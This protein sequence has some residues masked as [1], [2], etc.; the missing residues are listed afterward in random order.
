MSM[1]R[2]RTCSRCAGGRHCRYQDGNTSGC[3]MF[4]KRVNPYSEKER[5]KSEET[6]L[7]GGYGAFFKTLSV[8]RKERRG[9]DIDDSGD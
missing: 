7:N 5:K 6:N 2:C 8:K 9:K 3:S 1:G 4:I